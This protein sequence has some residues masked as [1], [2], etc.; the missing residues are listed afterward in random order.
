MHHHHHHQKKSTAALTK[1]LNAHKMCKTTNDNVKKE[2]ISPYYL[3]S[4]LKKRRRSIHRRENKSQRNSMQRLTSLK[5][6]S[7]SRERHKTRSRPAD[8]SVDSL[9]CTCLSWLSRR[10]EEEMNTPGKIHEWKKEKRAEKKQTVICSRE[11]RAQQ[12]QELKRRS[13]LEWPNVGQ[14]AQRQ[15]C[16]SSKSF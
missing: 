7:M 13:G 14:E 4:S 12:K 2:N 10:V 8:A 15:H 9:S 11:N 6:W 5:C 3:Y 16:S 1:H